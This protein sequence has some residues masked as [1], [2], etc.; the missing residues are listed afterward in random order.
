MGLTSNPFARG[1][2]NSP[3][4]PDFHAE[5]RD[6]VAHLGS[7]DPQRARFG[8]RVHRWELRPPLIEDA[9][10]AIEGHLAVRLPDDYRTHLTE[11]G[12]GGAGPYYG[13]M[14]LD[15]PAQLG[16]LRGPFGFSAPWLPEQGRVSEAAWRDHL[17]DRWL[18]GTVGLAHLGCGMVAVLVVDGAA[19]GQVWCDARGHGAGL[20]PIHASFQEF[21]LEWVRMA[22]QQ[23]WPVTPVAPASCAL[24]SALSSYLQQVEQQRGLAPGSLGGEALR[25]A[26]GQIGDGGIATTADGTGAFFDAGDVLDLCSNCERLVENLLPR[27]LRRSQLRPGI[28]ARPQR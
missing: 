1:A 21:Y 2:C 24:P 22:A 26:L 16:L 5:L 23:E 13:L 18:R 28:P 12:N 4:V 11:V 7:H 19:R 25:A 17:D 14:R 8:A 10:A 9:V 20:F 3:R 15:H 6:M 27:G